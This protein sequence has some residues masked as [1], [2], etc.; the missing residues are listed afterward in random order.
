MTTSVRIL[1]W[2]EI[3]IQVEADDGT[4]KLSRP[5]DARFQEAADAIAMFDGSFGSDD[6]LDAWEWQHYADYAGAP[7]EV[8]TQVATTFNSKMPVDFVARIRDS[9]TADRRDPTPGA[10]NCWLE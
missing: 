1:Y 5:L 4:T 6:Y 8:A 3:P 2:K 9:I 7:D 10:I